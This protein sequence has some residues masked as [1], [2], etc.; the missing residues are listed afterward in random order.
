MT[1]QAKARWLGGILTVVTVVAIVCQVILVVDQERREVSTL[2]GLLNGTI[3]G[4]VTQEEQ[5]K[6]GIY[7]P[8]HDDWDKKPILWK[9][10]DDGTVKDNA[11]AITMLTASC[12]I[13]QCILVLVTFFVVDK[14]RTKW[15]AIYSWM[16]AVAVMYIVI[17]IFLFIRSA[18]AA[19][20]KDWIAMAFI[21]E[22][23][24][25]MLCYRLFFDVTD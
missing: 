21:L 12:L 6:H 14:V 19:S 10:K 3:Y 13:V 4:N 5:E 20:V 15:K 1:T 17:P 11:R 23:V 24:A 25:V 8:S 22:T 9:E 18:A 2:Q 7:V 16:V